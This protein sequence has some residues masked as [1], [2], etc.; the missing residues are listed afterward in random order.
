MPALRLCSLGGF[1]YGIVKRS[2]GPNHL[3]AIVRD[4]MFASLGDCFM[5]KN[6]ATTAE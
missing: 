5:N 4:R 6:N 2:R 1:S 3:S